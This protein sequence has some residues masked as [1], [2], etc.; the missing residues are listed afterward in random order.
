MYIMT[1]YKR[2]G[3]RWTINEMLQ[4]QREFELLNMPLEEIAAVHQRTPNAILFKLDQEGFA[5]YDTLF[6]K[7]HNLVAP[8][9]DIIVYDDVSE[10]NMATESFSDDDSSSPSSLKQHMVRLEKQIQSLT[11]MMIR[12]SQKPSLFLA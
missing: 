8:T 12:Q 9:H 7:Y 1:A 4:L 5:D 11:Q 3:N 2:T 10:V 6:A